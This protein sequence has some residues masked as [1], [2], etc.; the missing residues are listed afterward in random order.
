MMRSA[1]VFAFA[2]L[3]SFFSVGSLPAQETSDHPKFTIVI[4][5]DKP[6]V[7]SGSN[8]EIVITTTNVSDELIPM[9]F[10][11]HGNLPDGFHYEVRDEQGAEVAKIV[12]NDIRPSRGPGSTRS[13]QL[14]PGKSKEDRAIISDVYPFDRPGKYTIKVWRRAANVLDDSELNRV[15]S[16]TITITVLP[17]G[18]KS[19][20]DEPSPTQQ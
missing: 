16:N 5:P 7:I 9:E 15:Y 10:G 14:A 20:A 3:A 17:A 11:G 18:S 6:E 8:V 12:Y 1:T 13:G 2:F 4:H 19:P